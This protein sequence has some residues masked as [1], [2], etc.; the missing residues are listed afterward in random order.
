MICNSSNIKLELE[1]YFFN[2]KKIR[3]DLDRAN[4]LSYYGK[5]KKWPKNRK[6]NKTCS[7]GSKLK[8]VMWILLIAFSAQDG[9]NSNFEFKD[10][11]M[12]TY[13][14]CAYLESIMKMMIWQKFSAVQLWNNYIHYWV[15]WSHFGNMCWWMDLLL[16][17][18]S[19]N[20]T[21]LV[22]W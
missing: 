22:S 8:F 18:Y 2:F 4:F 11:A 9:N 14:I 1:L 12:F 6:Q 19:L 21:N 16:L 20:K 5:T 15:F 7:P 17:F 13:M 3:S 10:F